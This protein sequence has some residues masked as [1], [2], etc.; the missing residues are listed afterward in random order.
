[1]AKKKASEYNGKR[2]RLATERR[3][4]ILYPGYLFYGEEDYL[5]RSDSRFL[6]RSLGVQEKDMNCTCFSGGQTQPEAVLETA[7]TL[8]FFAERRVILI[9][10]SGWFAA[11]KRGDKD[12]SEDAGE[13]VDAS[14]SADESAGGS[15]AGRMLAEYF[16]HPTETTQIIFVERDVNRTTALFKALDKFGFTLSCDQPA[17][18]DLKIWIAKKLADAGFRVEEKAAETLLSLCAG[19]LAGEPRID[20]NMLKNEMD[21]LISYCMGREAVTTADVR[22]VCS[23]SLTDSVFSMVDHM[24]RGDSRGAMALYQDMLAM[25]QAPF[26][27]LALIRRQFNNILLVTE[28]AQAGRSQEEI[29]KKLALHPFVV[30]MCAG[31]GRDFGRDRVRQILTSCADSEMAIKRGRMTDMIAV[32]TLIAGA[33]RDKK[34]GTQ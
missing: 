27:I 33:T 8:P 6:L 13:T 14:G 32:E 25:K 11:K 23:D 18:D 26:K 15:A 20:M 31:W 4:G 17:E 29:A 10:D 12:T 21:K 2:Q 1:M 22:A 5:R 9:E 30:K 16:K 19:G 7:M 34:G 3:E 28:L 24:A